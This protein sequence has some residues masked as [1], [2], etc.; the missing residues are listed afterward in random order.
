MDLYPTYEG[1]NFFIV[2]WCPDKLQVDSNFSPYYAYKSES[3]VKP[4]DY[5]STYCFRICLLP[6]LNGRF[7]ILR[8]A[9]RIQKS[10]K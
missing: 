4:T 1:K 8:L 10:G 7:T 3:R 6:V 5:V 9:M 2:H